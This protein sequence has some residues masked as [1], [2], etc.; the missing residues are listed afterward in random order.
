MPSALVSLKNLE[1]PQLVFAALVMA[2]AYVVYVVMVSIDE[3]YRLIEAARD[4]SFVILKMTAFALLHVA[5][6]VALFLAR[7]SKGGSVA[8]I[9]WV[10]ALLA[11]GYSVISLYINISAFIRYKDIV[12]KD[13][14]MLTAMALVTGPKELSTLLQQIK[15]D[16]R[17]MVPGG[18]AINLKAMLEGSSALRAAVVAVPNRK[19][20]QA[21]HPRAYPLLLMATALAD[22]IPLSTVQDAVSRDSVLNT[23]VLTGNSAVAVAPTT[24]NTRA[25][26]VSS[27]AAAGNTSA[28]VGVA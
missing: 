13:S 17:Y 4:S 20:L 24:G 8:Y 15:V 3:G 14:R 26:M 18:T 5:A 9:M 10:A 21:Q 19:A 7:A 2:T 12:V 16:P 1:A 23:S 28:V 25:V 11:L 6:V 22:T 27:A